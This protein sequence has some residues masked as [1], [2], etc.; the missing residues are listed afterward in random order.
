M[1]VSSKYRGLCETCDHDA[2]CTLKRSSRLEIIHCEQFSTQPVT[3][4]SCSADEKDAAAPHLPVTSF[5]PDF[6]NSH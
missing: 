6:R 2:G 3:G 5:R 1:A 4:A